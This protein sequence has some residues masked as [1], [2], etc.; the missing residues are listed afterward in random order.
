MVKERKLYVTKVDK[1]GCILIL[2]ADVVDG[3]MLD[4]LNEM[5]NFEKLAEDPR[6]NIRKLIKSAM[7]DY[8]IRG[9]LN[10]NDLF[11]VTGITNRG[12]TSHG[13]EFIV[14]K[15]HMYPLFK[16]HKLNEE[17]ILA[18]VI[19]PTRMVTSGVGGPTFRLGTFL[20]NLLKPVV[21]KYC[22]NEVVRDS[23]AVSYTHLTLP[24]ICSV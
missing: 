12:G 19:P 10:D 24:T 18:K 6:D 4:T 17:K 2:N 23:T 1:G 5:K 11:D 3:I 9:L 16:I 7:S 8:V 20:D 14:G 21:L 15:P 13:R 22:R